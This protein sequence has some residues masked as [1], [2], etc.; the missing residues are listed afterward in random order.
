MDKDSECET[1][2]SDD[3]RQPNSDKNEESD[4]LWGKVATKLQCSL[5]M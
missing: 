2:A 5:K 3:G 4:T 1:D